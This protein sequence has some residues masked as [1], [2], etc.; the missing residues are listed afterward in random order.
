MSARVMTVTEATAV[1]RGS[2]VRDAVTITWFRSEKSSCATAMSGQP[3][4]SSAATKKSL[5]CQLLHALHARW[6]WSGATGKEETDVRYRRASQTVWHRPARAAHCVSR[7]VSGLA[8]GSLSLETAPSRARSTVVCR[9]L[10]L[11]YRCVGS[12]GIAFVWRMRTGFP[13]HP[14]GAFAPQGH[15]RRVGLYAAVFRR[16]SRLRLYPARALRR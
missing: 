8:S 14:K 12:A 10:G 16:A 15:L 6:G 1:S 13:F 2:E 11:A 7:P 3:A 5:T 4:E 9:G